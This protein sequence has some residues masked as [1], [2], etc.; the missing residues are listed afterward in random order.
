MN[1][2]LVED[3][4]KDIELILYTI[5]TAFEIN[6]FTVTNDGED[7]IDFLFCKGRYADREDDPPTLILLD[8]ILPKIRGDKVLEQIRSDPK[9]LNIPVFLFS[10][11]YDKK[12]IDK[13]KKLGIIGHSVKSEGFDQLI[14]SLDHSGLLPKKYNG[15]SSGNAVSGK[16]TL[17]ISSEELYLLE[18]TIKTGIESAVETLNL[19][20]GLPIQ[21]N[22]LL[23]N[24][25]PAYDLT[26]EMIERLNTDQSGIRVVGIDFTGKFS[27]LATFAIAVE[28]SSD[29]INAFAEEFITNDG[30]K[31]DIFSEMGN[32]LIN[33]IIGSIANLLKIKER[34]DFSTPIYFETAKT[35]IMPE[36]S[37]PIVLVIQL[38]F[39]VKNKLVDS[40]IVLS[41]KQGFFEKFFTIVKMKA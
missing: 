8:L 34:F 36:G 24:L 37:S 30:D 21:L 17:S 27:G 6:H 9:T 18:K 40:D 31:I 7:A 38:G 33:S 23:I 2:L 13:C 3:N 28:N 32:I 15:Q 20:T 39:K 12:I 11:I 22:I 25:L 10:D 4:P 16:E 5:N 19:M 35:S 41:F 26:T 1:L 29:I 14:Q